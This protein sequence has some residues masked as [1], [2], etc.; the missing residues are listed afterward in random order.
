[1][2]E[3]PQSSQK[4]RHQCAPSTKDKCCHVTS[5]EKMRSKFH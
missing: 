1:M 2:N 5:M 3:I 4:I